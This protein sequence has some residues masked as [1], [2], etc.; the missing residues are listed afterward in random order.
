LVEAQSRWEAVSIGTDGT[1]RGHWV[2]QPGAYA[3]QPEQDFAVVIWLHG[4]GRGGDGSVAQLQRLLGTG[5][6]SIIDSDTHPLRDLF[7]QRDV[8]VLAPQLTD[9]VWWKDSHI[10]PFLDWSMAHYRLDAS[11]IWLTGQSAG[12]SGIHHFMNND[13]DARNVAAFLPVAVRGRVLAGEGDYLGEWVPYWAMTARGDA[14]NTATRSVDALANFRS[15][16]TT[17]DVMADY[18]NPDAVH[19]AVFNGE[20][21]LWRQQQVSAEALVSPKLTLYP[22]SEHNSWDRAYDNPT[23]WEWLFGQ[24][25]PRVAI[26]R[27]GAGDTVFR[28]QA[29]AIEALVETWQGRALDAVSWFSDVDGF[30]GEDVNGLLTLDSPGTHQLSVQVR[31]VAMGSAQAEILLEVAESG[32]IFADRFEP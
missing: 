10:R 20:Q 9:G 19:T 16:G 14:S 32:A 27:P 1:P 21:W 2:F 17:S 26:T 6:P 22:G 8:V 18:P 28:G 4:L 23:V 3:N 24:V 13:P 11:R 25:K 12:A 31:D 5:P 30:L 15:G 29:F 7:E